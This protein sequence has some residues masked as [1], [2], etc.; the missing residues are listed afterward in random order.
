M[1]SDILLSE[2]LCMVPPSAHGLFVVRDQ[3]SFT[4]IVSPSVNQM[5]KHSMK[6]FIPI[7]FGIDV[8][9]L[10]T[11]EVLSFLQVG[12]CNQ[13]IMLR[14]SQPFSYS[15]FPNHLYLP[16]IPTSPTQLSRTHPATTQPN[17]IHPDQTQP[18]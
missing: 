7:R 11:S 6:P 2:T 18:S 12:F 3:H 15:Q 10:F 14:W 17:R 8:A 1:R 5:I 4:E 16:N 9:T 13:Y